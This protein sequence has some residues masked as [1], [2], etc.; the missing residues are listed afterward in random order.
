MYPVCGK[1]ER[2][3]CKG[4]EQALQCA[5]ASNPPFSH[6]ANS[7]RHRKPAVGMEPRAEEGSG[8][9]KGS[10]WLDSL[11]FSGTGLTLHPWEE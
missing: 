11:L 8:R 5:F 4:R 2:S 1:T 9:D 10:T 6:K 7:Q 3:L